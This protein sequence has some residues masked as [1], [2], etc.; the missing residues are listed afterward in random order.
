MVQNLGRGARNTPTLHALVREVDTIPYKPWP[1]TSLSHS[2]SFSPC[3]HGFRSTTIPA[4]NKIINNNSQLLQ[5]GIFP[6]VFKP[7]LGILWNVRERCTDEERSG[8]KRQ[9]AAPRAL[10]GS[11]STAHHH[12]AMIRCAGGFMRTRS[13]MKRPSSILLFLV[14]FV[15]CHCIPA[16]V[17]GSTIVPRPRHSL[18]KP[19]GFDAALG[20][21]QK[22]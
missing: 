22:D 19:L 13:R 16:V 5:L 8:R 1:S 11:G 18:P 7:Q 10:R 3:T 12:Q 15:S 21:K 17:S 2:H 14:C 4:V 20:T 9:A 6:A